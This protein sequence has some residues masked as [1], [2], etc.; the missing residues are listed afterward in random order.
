VATA[1][2]IALA[3]AVDALWWTWRAVP[4]DASLLSLKLADHAQQLQAVGSRIQ[5]ALE[6]TLL[7]DDEPVPPNAPPA[8]ARLTVTEAVILTGAIMRLQVC[9]P[10]R[11]C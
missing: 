8:A 11:D 10:I 7:D 1:L 6:A 4:D 3:R 2:V 9:T 5:A